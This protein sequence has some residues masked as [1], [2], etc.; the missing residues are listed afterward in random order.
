MRRYKLGKTNISVSPIGF[1]TLTIGPF[2]LNLPI[3]KGS[4]LIV[5][6]VRRGINLIDTAKIYM[7]YPYV[8][9]ALRILSDDEKKGLHI[10]SRS[11][12]CS[13]EGMK[14]SFGEA[15]RGMNIEKISIFML[16]EQLSE[17]TL[18][19]HSEAIDYLK[20]MKERGYLDAI[21]ISTHYTEA[22]IAASNN[23]DID[24]IFAILNSGGLGIMDS[25]RSVMEKALEG[26]FKKGK[27][28][29]LM[30]VMGGGH[31][32]RNARES[33]EYVRNLS[34]VHSS[35][36]GMQSIEEID[37][38]RGILD[39][40][41]PINF[42]PHL[43]GSKDR[44]IFIEPWCCGCG[45]C[46]KAC[47]FAALKIKDGKAFVLKDKCMLCSYCAQHCSDFCIKVV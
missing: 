7:T 4:Y 34:F 39:S 30:K 21:G 43:P 33:L 15:L 1:G 16:H 20:E 31:L 9:E 3:Q 6:A 23:P 17:A 29:L 12:D 14:E 47:P 46:I 45:S 44:E 35:I 32:Y 8:A 27:G 37:Y 40:D 25:N 38:N 5:E 41:V 19:G 28:I 13:Y 2:Q 26:A 10:I 36:I 42:P 11:Y 22:V 18:R 24:V